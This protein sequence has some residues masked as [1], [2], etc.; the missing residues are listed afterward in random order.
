MP[1]IP[2]L[3]HLDVAR[4]HILSPSARYPCVSSIVRSST[5]LMLLHHAR[6]SERCSGS[7][8]S[9]GENKSLYGCLR[10]IEKMPALSPVSSWHRSGPEFGGQKSASET[11][12]LRAANLSL[13]FLHMSAP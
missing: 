2:R 10:S 7:A 9:I 11:A 6:S 12:A 5:S 8:S 1:S 3:S 4:R 13:S